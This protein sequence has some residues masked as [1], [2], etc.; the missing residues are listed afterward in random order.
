LL[1]SFEALPMADRRAV[2]A[3][4]LRLAGQE[5]PSPPD[6]SLAS[7]RD[8]LLAMAREA[9]TLAPALPEDLAEHHD[10]Y[11]HGAPRP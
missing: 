5:A 9:E 3:E 8:W 10:H 1:E 4:I 11:A 2:A 6:D 7:T